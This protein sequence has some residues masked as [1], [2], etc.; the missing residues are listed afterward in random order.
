MQRVH[1]TPGLI[2][3]MW[4]VDGTHLLE[5]IHSL[6][7]DVGLTPRDK[8]EPCGH[9]GSA[10]Y[11]CWSGTVLESADSVRSRDMARH[12]QDKADVAAVVADTSQ[13]PIEYTDTGAG[14]PVLFLH[15]S[16]GGCDQGVLMSRFLAVHHR[17]IAISRPGYLNTPLAERNRTPSAQ[18]DQVA[19]L[20]STLGID[21]FGV[22]CWS[23]GGP[24]SYELAA[25]HP[26]RVAAVAVIAGV[27]TTFNPA[28]TLR[29]RLEMGEE[30]MLFTRLG[31]W[32][33]N[34]LVDKAAATA[35]STLVAGEGDMTRS[36]AI[37]LTA[38]IMSDPGQRQF[39][40]ELFSTVTG[41][42][43]AGFNNDFEQFRTLDLPLDAITAPVLLV[44]A[45][46]DAD[47]PFEQSV[48]ATDSLPNS[49]LMT[50]D[51][52]SHLSAWLGPDAGAVQTAVVRHFRLHLPW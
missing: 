19:E 3:L 1:Q 49:R 30:R 43:K 7:S 16:P 31:T 23:G 10:P 4:P 22:M 32:F 5:V 34:A 52:G 40:T 18:A 44:H 33:A 20:M 38:Q 9:A 45:R 39:A 47:V 17:I 21:R 25:A 26:G 37:Q 13:G 11:E 28:R 2:I 48:R 14:P 15:G 35:I 42:R 41:N 27:S 12:G 6:S 46:T 50:I 24:V 36:Q 8:T 29:G 51:V